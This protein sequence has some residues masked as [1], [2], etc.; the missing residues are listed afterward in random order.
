MKKILLL[1]IFTLLP[2][3]QT[4]S[5]LA[6]KEKTNATSKLSNIGDGKKANK[7]TLPPKKR[8]RMKDPSP[9]S[10]SNPEALH[11]D[12]SKPLIL[13]EEIKAPDL[14]EAI[15]LRTDGQYADAYRIFQFIVHNNKRSLRDRITAQRHIISLYTHDQIAL[16]LIPETK[17]FLEKAL[18]TAGLIFYD[19]DFPSSDEIGIRILYLSLLIHHHELACQIN[20]TDNWCNLKNLIKRK[21]I[22]LNEQLSGRMQVIDNFM[23]NYLSD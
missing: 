10:K 14:N 12:L 9:L 5:I 19:D 8:I 23:L 7:Q 6:G 13:L 11:K 15:N 22:A 21:N 3:T 4:Y 20:L 17:Y 16:P 1:I 18:D 2:H